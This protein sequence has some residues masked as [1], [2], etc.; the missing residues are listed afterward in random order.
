MSLYNFNSIQSEITE[1]KEIE[2][3]YLKKKVEKAK[4]KKHELLVEEEEISK[5]LIS[6]DV[7]QLNIVD[8]ICS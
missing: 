2:K 8:L 1:I 7:S 6:L 3:N 4:E 5:I